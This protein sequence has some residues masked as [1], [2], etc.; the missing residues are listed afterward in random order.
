MAHTKADV[1]IIGGGVIGIS[2]AYYL[3]LQGVKATVIDKS[4]PGLGCSY[5]NAGWITPCFA[6]PLPL[7]GMLIKSLKW[8][9]DPMSPLHIQPKPSLLL[10]RWMFRFLRSMNWKTAHRS[11]QALTE[12]S[13]FSLSEYSRM[14]QEFGTDFGFS[15]KGLLLVGLTSEGVQAAAQEQELVGNYGIPGTRLDE[16]QVKELE[17]ALTG[18]L[19]GGVYFPNEAHCEPLAFVRSLAQKAKENGVEIVSGAEVFDFEVGSRKI[20]SVRTTRGSFYADQFVLATGSWS[21]AIARTL[22]IRVPVLGGKGYA[23]I[24][25]PFDPKPQIPLMLIEKKIAVT[26]RKDSV[27]LAGTLELV[28]LDFSINPKRVDSIIAGSQLCM[29][30]PKELEV[31]ELWRGLRPCTPDGVPVIGYSSH[32]SNLILAT[33]HQMLGL[34]SAPGT[35][36][37]VADLVTRVQPQF[38]PAPFCAERF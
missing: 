12:I 7:P 26:P 11:I 33:G 21:N 1:L 22:K 5:G 13:K 30:V 25:K 4:E 20:H 2:C 24:V 28:N 16:A 27:R 35:G 8:L 36:K 18:P 37:L 10:F 14:S 6:L 15:Q 17:P 19:T 23:L 31:L 3:S 34:Q 9:A 29:N 32:F 38:D